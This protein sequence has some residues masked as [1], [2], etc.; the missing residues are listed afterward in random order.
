MRKLPEFCFK[1]VAILENVLA[2]AKPNKALIE[3][4]VDKID[5]GKIYA[6][7][8]QKSYIFNRNGVGVESDMTLVAAGATDISKYRSASGRFVRPSDEVSHFRLPAEEVDEEETDILVKLAEH[9]SRRVRLRISNGDFD[10]AIVSLQAAK[11]EHNERLQEI[12]KASELNG[13]G[14]SIQILGLSERAKNGLE[15]LGCTT[16]FDICTIDMNTLL[17]AESV[18]ARTYE[19]IRIIL[20]KHGFEHRLEPINI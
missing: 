7:L 5:R 12:Q 10:G 16:I 17:N 11:R 9:L 3:L 6:S 15:S 19:H 20:D 13:L 1:N 14:A 2:L 4:T 18:G 8:G